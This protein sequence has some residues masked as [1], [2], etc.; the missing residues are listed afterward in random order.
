MLPGGKIRMKRESDSR[1]QK[2]LFDSYCLKTEDNIVCTFD[3]Y[4]IGNPSLS[5]TI[6]LNRNLSSI[7][8]FGAEKIPQIRSIM[9]ESDVRY[10]ENAKTIYRVSGSE[11]S[12]KEAPGYI[13][14]RAYANFMDEKLALI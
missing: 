3:D 8:G 9:E 14:G 5:K 13:L 11:H 6:C 2:S 1:L 10:L 4:K 7:D 12:F